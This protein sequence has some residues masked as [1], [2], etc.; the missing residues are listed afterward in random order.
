[1]KQN[2]ETKTACFYFKA[3]VDRLA[4]QLESQ[5]S[6]LS[7]KLEETSRHNADLAARQQKLHSE[8]ANLLSQLEDAESQVSGFAKTKQQLHA[9]LEEAK[10]SGEEEARAR[11]SKA[12]ARQSAEAQQWRT[13]YETEGLVKAEELEEAKRKLSAKLAE[14]EDQVS[15]LN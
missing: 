12:L 1:M 15:Y 13:K 9:Q 2:R 5:L 7:V 4:K 3:N 6:E 8:N 11:A 14:A 10:R